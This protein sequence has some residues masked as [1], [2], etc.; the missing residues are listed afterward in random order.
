[1]AL[2]T[3]RHGEHACIDPAKVSRI[4]TDLAPE[5]GLNVRAARAA[6]LPLVRAARNGGAE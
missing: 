6:L 3:E 2:V 5:V 4:A 1:M